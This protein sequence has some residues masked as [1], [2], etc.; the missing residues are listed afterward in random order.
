V[1]ETPH[2]LV[3]PDDLS[4]FVEFMVKTKDWDIETIVYFLGK[5]WKWAPEYT[6]W[7]GSQS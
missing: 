4:A 2:D 3:L 6:A 1:S 7:K 5:P